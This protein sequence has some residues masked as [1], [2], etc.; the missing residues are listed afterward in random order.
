[1]TLSGKPH[2]AATQSSIISFGWRMQVWLPCFALSPRVSSA[3]AQT[4]EGLIDESPPSTF[5]VA[6]HC[7]PGNN[8]HHA[9]TAQFGFSDY[10]YF[11]VDVPAAATKLNQQHDATETSG[12]YWL[13]VAKGLK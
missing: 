5:F 13:F 9:G 8:Q 7:G 1:M 4:Q 6:N 3:I 12:T 11:V 2:C 10:G